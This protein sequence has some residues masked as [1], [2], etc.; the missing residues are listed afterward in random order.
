M[1]RVWSTGVIRSFWKVL[2]EG[3][4]WKDGEMERWRAAGESPHFQASAAKLRGIQV[5]VQNEQGR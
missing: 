5:T 3:E 2:G 1:I 4:G